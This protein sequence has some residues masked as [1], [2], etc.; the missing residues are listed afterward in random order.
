MNRVLNILRGH[1]AAPA[2][3]RNLLDR[4]RDE[5][6]E[7]AFTELV[8]RYGPVVWGACRR[9]LANTQDAEDAFQAAFLVLLRRAAKLDHDTPLGPWLY[10]VAVL[11][12][13]NV[14]R[15]NRRRAAVNGPMEHEP[16]APAGPDVQRLDLDAA[17]LALSERERAAVVLCHLQGFTRREAAAQLGCPE[18][19]LSARL[20]RALS[21]LRARLGAGA[22]VALTAS[23]AALP[24][25][26][27][28]ATTRSA[29]VFATSKLAAPGLSPAVAQLADGVLRMFWMKKALAVGAILMLGA[30]ALTLGFAG[31]ADNARATE[32]P[33]QATAAA[34]DEDDTIKQLEKQLADL[35]K[36]QELLAKRAAEVMRERTK[37]QEAMWEKEEAEA[38]AKLGKDIVVIVGAT[39]APRP[40]TVR[41]V[42]NGRVA[43]VTCFSLDALTTYLARAHADPKGPEALRVSVYEDHPAAEVRK[44]LA[45]CAKAGYAKATFTR[46]ERPPVQF[47]TRT[48]ILLADE[49][50][51][52]PVP[53]KIDLRK[54]AEPKKQP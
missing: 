29:S 46:T 41:E 10:R 11:T 6:D 54:Y 33:P 30:G 47:M 15:A 12:A 4:F 52:D 16:P 36:Q 19:T 18:G 51:I 38:A 32:P 14:V 7:A 27:A 13:R 24:A 23:G 2:S 31:R 45:A 53:G 48:K 35:Q 40:F 8:R 28:H 42:V 49:L 17:L 5:R 39:S 1:S 37:R 21:R 3:D 20:D 34:S 9:A 43:E 25:G 50:V 44:V 26:L 22:S